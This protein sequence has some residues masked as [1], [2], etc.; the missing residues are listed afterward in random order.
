MIMN[1][2]QTQILSWIVRLVA[3]AILLQTL[4]FKF[5]GAPESGYI[6]SRLGM[7]PLGRYGSGALELLASILLLLPR[8]SVFGALLS[9]GVMTGAIGS[10]LTVLGIDVQGDG[11]TLFALALTVTACS[12]VELF[13]RRSSL[14]GLVRWKSRGT[15]TGVSR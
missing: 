10:H 9:L 1:E 2:R 3:A 5:T 7:E 4:F 13:L 15:E 14:P 12:T 8:T 11:G 6:F